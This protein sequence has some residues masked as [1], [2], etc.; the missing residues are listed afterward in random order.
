MWNLTPFFFESIELKSKNYKISI[1]E[2]IATFPMDFFVCFPV[3]HHRVPF[4][5]FLFICIAHNISPCTRTKYIICFN[6]L[7]IFKYMFVV[8]TILTYKFS[9]CEHL[10]LRWFATYHHRC[11]MH[12]N[13]FL[14]A[15]KL[16]IY[17]T[18]VPWIGFVLCF[19][20]QFQS[21]K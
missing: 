9:F 6:R 19:L 18:E 3:H 4:F 12:G 15:F 21:I 16:R 5:F 10:Q 13:R 20:D 8:E 11:K 14:W 17:L 7:L 2:P 1:W